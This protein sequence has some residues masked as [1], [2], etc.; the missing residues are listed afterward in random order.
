[1]ADKNLRAKLLVQEGDYSSRYIHFYL[2]I[3]E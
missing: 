3:N 1:M 2:I